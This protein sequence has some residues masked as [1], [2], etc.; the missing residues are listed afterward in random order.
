MYCPPGTQ[1]MDLNPLFRVP[2]PY[3]FGGVVEDRM[4]AEHSPLGCDCLVLRP[5]EFSAGAAAYRETFLYPIAGPNDE[6]PPGD[7]LYAF[8]LKSYHL[9]ERYFVLEELA[10]ADDRRR[11]A[12]KAV[13]MEALQKASCADLLDDGLCQDLGITVG[14]FTWEERLEIL[15]MTLQGLYLR[16]GDADAMNRFL[17]ALG[18]NNPWPDAPDTGHDEWSLDTS[19]N[20]ALNGLIH[21]LS[22]QQDLGISLNIYFSSI[23]RAILPLNRLLSAYLRAGKSLMLL[24]EYMKKHPLTLY[25]GPEEKRTNGFRVGDWRLESEMPSS[26]KGIARVVG[27]DGEADQLILRTETPEAI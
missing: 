9:R 20:S 18:P 5:L 11:I 6:I 26:E 21:Q 12:P 8:R 17:Q 10:P 15:S 24:P 16:S 4:A 25:F 27:Y 22:Q 14:Q 2:Y 13:F 3:W 23:L 19:R 1:T 7:T